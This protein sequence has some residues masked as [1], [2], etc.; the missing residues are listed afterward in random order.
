MQQSALLS[1]PAQ[2]SPAHSSPVPSTQVKSHPRNYI[3][4][5]FNPEHPKSIKDNCNNPVPWSAVLSSPVQAYP[6][7][8]SA[9]YFNLERNVERN[10]LQLSQV[11]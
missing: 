9:V 2:S 10:A 11:K 1:G 8:Y 6:L 5:Y 7:K 4:M 3:V